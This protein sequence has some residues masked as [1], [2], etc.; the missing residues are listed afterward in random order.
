MFRFFF[1]F[2]IFVSFL[3]AK[4][5]KELCNEYGLKPGVKA[6]IQWERIFKSK[7]RQKRL[8]IDGLNDEDK[9]KLEKFLIEHA[10]DSAHPMV[11]GL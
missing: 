7:S 4:S 3:D 9:K 2:F 1:V 10:A 11:P 8:G 6:S 5:P